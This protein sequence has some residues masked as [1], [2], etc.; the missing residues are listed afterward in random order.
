ML[1]PCCGNRWPD[2]GIPDT[3]TPLRRLAHLLKSSDPTQAGPPVV[4]CSAG[5]G[6]TGTFVVIHVILKRL[7]ALEPDD[8]EGMQ[9]CKSLPL[10]T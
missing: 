3:T 4:H 1:I 5:I 2:F 10:T 8:V 7:L 9:L 6:R